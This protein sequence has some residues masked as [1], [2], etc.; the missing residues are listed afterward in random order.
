V[1]QSEWATDVAF[2]QRADL[3]AWYP[4]WVRHAFTNFPTTQVLRFLGRSGR[5]PAGTTVD[6]HSDVQAVDESVRLKHWVNGNS[7]KVYDHG[8]VLRVETTINA[9]QEFR[10]YR[11]AVGDPDGPQDWR[12]LRRSVADTY[13]RAEVSQAANARYLEALASVAAPTTLAEL[14]APWC[15]RVA[16]PGS[17][18]RKVRAL[19]PW[20]ADAALLRAV[21][22]PRWQ[23]N[24]LR[25]RDVAEALFGAAP[26]DAAARRRRSAQ[27]TRLLRLLR[28]HGI[29]KKVPKTQRYVVSPPSRDALLALAAARNAN[30]A[31]LT[32]SAA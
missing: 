26:A 23:V 14:L 18:G 32:A 3:E 10:S 28:A 20:G 25:N 5:L 1:H 12:V 7:L 2:R 13:R 21:S 22:D 6:V 17:S 9:P 8:T 11:S 31:T 27:V 30:A 15:Q 4:R 16:A 19:N 24:G 29:L